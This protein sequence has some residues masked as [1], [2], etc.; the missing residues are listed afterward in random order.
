MQ[1][2]GGKQAVVAAVLPALWVALLALALAGPALSAGFWEP[3]ELRAMDDLVDQA[4][5]TPIGNS[6]RRINV[7]IAS[8]KRG[9]AAPLVARGRATTANTTAWPEHAGP[10]RTLTRELIK[11]SRELAAAADVPL[12]ASTTQTATPGHVGNIA[13]QTRLPLVWLGV[14]AALLTYTLGR[15]IASR[16]AAV[17]ASLILLATPLWALQTRQLTS[18]LGA[19]IGGLLLLSGVVAGLRA[20]ATP[21]G[22]LASMACAAL[23]TWCCLR[24]GG[25]LVGVAPPLIAGLAYAFVVARSPDAARQ[26][27]RVAAALLGVTLLTTLAITAMQTHDARPP[28][29]GTRQWLGTSFVPSGELSSWLGAVW[30]TQPQPQAH[31]ASAFEHVAFGMWPWSGIALIAVLSLAASAWRRE[32]RASTQPNALAADATKIRFAAAAA[33]LVAWTGAAW[34]AMALWQLNVGGVVIFG[35]SAAMALAC[36]LWW[37]QHARAAGGQAAMAAVFIATAIAALAK[38]AAVSHDAF[39]N[40]AS[41]TQLTG[42]AAQAGYQLPVHG[43]LGLTYATWLIGLGVLVAIATLPRLLASGGRLRKL[44][45][46]AWLSVAALVVALGYNWLIYPTMDG[47]LSSE[48][49]FA[50]A[51]DERVD[52]EAAGLYVLSELGRAP[53]YYDDRAWTKLT[54]VTELLPRLQAPAHALAIAGRKRDLC[55]IHRGMRSAAYYVLDN[56]NAQHVLLSNRP[57]RDGVD[58]NP[59]AAVMRRSE[60]TGI[61]VR[62]TSPIVFDHKLELIGWTLPASIARG[63]PFEV[64]LYFRVLAAVGGT[65]KL[66]GHYDGPSKTRF[67]SDHA[68]IGEL[69]ASS[70]WDAGDY[71]IDTYRVTSNH[72]SLPTGPYQL[73]VGF[74]TGTNPNFRNMPVSSAPPGWAD[75]QQR[76]RIATLPLR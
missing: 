39:A 28:T 47:Q 64:T 71:I 59:L 68:P 13:R 23:G 34:I 17:L 48:A 61:A 50:A 42:K 74:F 67:G 19:V 56:G 72:G 76:V 36:A 14:I 6:L 33:M 44:A 12:S 38:D 54:S 53:R 24:A 57:A 21:L 2:P 66:F 41:A 63:Q 58:H 70:T 3:L 5:G 62:P 65:W 22:L 37:H 52:E 29:P 49:L 73:W 16:G 35:G 27:A 45:P 43:P 18:E 51:R 30:S 46:T 11:P 40:F 20:R 31:A 7:A 1:T 60:P 9:V 15:L 32:D 69:C 4:S 10:G 26:R 8:A 25:A 75:A 55:A